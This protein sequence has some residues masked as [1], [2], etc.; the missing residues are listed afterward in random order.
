[1]PTFGMQVYMQVEDS[2]IKEILKKC[3]PIFIKFCFFYLFIY[4]LIYLFLFN[5]YDYNFKKCLPIFIKFCFFYL[6]IYLFLFNAYE[7]TV[8]IFRRGQQIPLQMVV[9]HHVVAGN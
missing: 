8:D 2:Y 3:L 5:A 6:F 1:M 7:Y 4:L 9:S